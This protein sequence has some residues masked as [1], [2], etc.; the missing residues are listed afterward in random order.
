MG[1][2]AIARVESYKHYQAGSVHREAVRELTNYSNP[3]WRKEDVHLN[4]Y[5]DRMDFEGLSFEK[6]VYKYREENGISGRYIE[7]SANQK[8]ETN[9]MCQAFFTLPKY[10]DT[11]ERERQIEV[12]QL[13]YDFFKKEFPDVPILEAVAHFDE[14]SPH[15]HISFLPV[16]ERIHKKRGKEKV[17]ST[18]LLMPGKDFFPKFQDRFFAY[19]QDHLE[20]DLDRSKDSGRLHYKPKEYRQLTEEIKTMEDHKKLML[21][22]NQAI[23]K[24]YKYWSDKLK[25]IKSTTALERTIKAYQKQRALQKEIDLL[26]MFLSK[27]FQALPHVERSYENF[28]SETDKNSEYLKYIGVFHHTKNTPNFGPMDLKIQRMLDMAFG[29]SYAEEYVKRNYS[30]ER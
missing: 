13:C 21:A 14:T 5:F 28:R 30:K 7:K 1:F 22:D 16:V 11:L 15:L 3:N 4:V 26:Y 29:T 25:E 6:F 2:S 23:Y 10:I 8:S 9:A 27:V 20:I 19:M 24:E 17:F 18:T 12:L